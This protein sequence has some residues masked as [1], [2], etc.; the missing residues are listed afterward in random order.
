MKEYGVKRG[1]KLGSDNYYHF[2]VEN[3]DKN[4]GPIPSLELALQT[5]DY[6]KDLEMIV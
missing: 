6:A 3:G 2:E 1:W 4:D 5:I